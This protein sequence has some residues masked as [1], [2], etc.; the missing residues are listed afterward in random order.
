MVVTIDTS[1][2]EGI[3]RV[4]SIQLLKKKKSSSLQKHLKLQVNVSL[5][6]KKSAKEQNV[7]QKPAHALT[8]GSLL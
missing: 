1:T 6:K 8:V 3:C 2:A 7:L 4:K 5:A